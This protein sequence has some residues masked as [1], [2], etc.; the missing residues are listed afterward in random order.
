MVEEKLSTLYAAMIN[1]C[2]LNSLDFDDTYELGCNAICYS[3]FSIIPAVLE[4]GECIRSSR[5]GCP[6]RNG[7]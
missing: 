6:S 3:G 5:Q 7:I 4:M 2:F 1:F